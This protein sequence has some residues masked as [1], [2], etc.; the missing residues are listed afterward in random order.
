[1]LRFGDLSLDLG[2]RE[3]QRGDRAFTLT[4]IEFD[5]LELFLRHPRQVLTR[6]VIL[7][8]V[9]GYNFDSGT[10]SLAVY[11]GYLRRKTEAGGEPRC[12]HTVRGVGLRAARAVTFRTRLVLVAAVA[13]VIAVLAASTASY[14]AARNSL[15]GSVDGTLLGHRH[16]HRHPPPDNPDEGTSGVDVQYVD[17]TR[18]RAPA[19]VD[20]GCRC[21]RPCGRWPPASQHDVLH[22]RHA[23]TASTTASWSYVDRPGALR[24]RHRRVRPTQAAP[25]AGRCR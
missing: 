14:F 23:R 22:H 13:V 25:A 5:L 18:D 4:R 16:K 6:D 12:L 21:R 10:N 1:M 9:W 2:T 15:L 17:P 20:L 8:R 24:R 11:V 3:A 19:T 7:D